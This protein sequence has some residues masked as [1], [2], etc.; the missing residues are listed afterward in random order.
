M[1]TQIK[2]RIEIAA[3]LL[4]GFNYTIAAST[5][6]LFIYNNKAT[7]NEKMFIASKILESV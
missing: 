1:L 6:T 7:K 3:K 4:F 2:K 5:N